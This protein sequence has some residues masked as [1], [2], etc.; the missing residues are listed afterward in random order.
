MTRR[1]WALFAAMGALW[2]LPYLLIKVAVAEVDPSVVVFLRLGLS[3]MIL[4]PIAFASGAFTRDLRQRWRRVG[5][6][7]VVGIVLPFLLIGYGEQHIT[8][9]LAALLVASDPLFIVALALVFDPSERTGG[10]RLIG[11][12]IG[13]VGVAALFGL[14]VSGDAYSML[15]GA[16]VLLA[17]LGYALSA[18]MVKGLSRV[19]RLGSVTATVTVAAVL[20]APLA[21]AHLPT[22][23][24]TPGVILAILVL[25][26][27]CTA[28]AYVLYFSLIVE[29]GA[30]RASLITYVNPA[31]A[32]LLGVLILSEPLTLGTILGFVLILIGCALATGVLRVPRRT[33]QAH[34]IASTSPELV[35]G[36]MS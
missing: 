5:L 3:A 21:T 35:E 7:A 2:G 11:L 17:A 20:I 27:L 31:V 26:L 29:A 30:S 18:L 24:P 36:R 13:L 25:S 10:T 4:V 33:R 28:V 22:S 8:S 9:S 23:L 16:M 15:G 32:V 1:A 6:I 19:P 12:V 34:R 14:D